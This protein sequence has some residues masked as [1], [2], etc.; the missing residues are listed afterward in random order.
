MLPV[1]DKYHFNGGFLFE[2]TE[3]ISVQ[4]RKGWLIYMIEE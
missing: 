4:P 2:E 1:I 3:S